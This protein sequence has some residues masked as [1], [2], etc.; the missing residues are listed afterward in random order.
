MIWKIQLSLLLIFTIL[1]VAGCSDNRHYDDQL[2]MEILQLDSDLDNRWS[3][4][5]VVVVDIN[6]NGPAGRAKP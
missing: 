2:Q 4:T 5:G 3:T 1:S 6:A